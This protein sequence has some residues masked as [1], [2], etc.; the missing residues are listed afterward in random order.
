[1]KWLEPCLAVFTPDGFQDFTDSFLPR[2]S[3]ISEDRRRLVRFLAG[4]AFDAELDAAGRVT[5]A[6]PLMEHAGLKKEVAIV[7]NLDYLEIWDRGRYEA[8]QSALP[9]AVVDIA[10]SLGHPS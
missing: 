10:N 4:S 9:A 7:G 8:E 3:P 6:A 1:M 5:L 2:L